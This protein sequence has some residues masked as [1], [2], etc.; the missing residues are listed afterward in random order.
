MTETDRRID[1]IDNR[2]Q[3]ARLA[4]ARA[5][6]HV[7]PHFT[8]RRVW[9]AAEWPV[10]DRAEGVYAWDVEGNRYLDGLSGLFCT[11]LGHGRRDLVEAMAAQAGRLAFSPT[12]N[13]T[14]PAAIAAAAAVAG[15]APDGLDH[16]F[17]VSSGS[18]AVESALKIVRCHHV[19][20]GRHERTKIIARRWSYHG[21]T[22][23]AL[24]VTGVPKLR[25][26]FE[27]V[28]FDGVT[29]A[30]NTR[31]AAVEGIDPAAAIEQAILDAGPDQV[32]AVF[33]EPVQNGGGAL[34]PPD[35][36][37]HALREIC[38]RHG[39]LLVADEV[40]CAFGRLGTPFGSHRVGA[41][42]DLITFAKGVTSAYVP[43]GGL[44]TTSDVLDPILDSQLGSFV[45]GSTFGAHPVAS[46]VA[47]AT[48][49][50]LHEEEV[51]EHVARTEAHL[52]DRLDALAVAHDSVAEV[53][54]CGFFY[55]IELTASRRRALP[56]T[57]EQSAQLLGG[58]LTRWI[59]DA[60]LLI[61]ADDR[62][63]TMLI[64]S[65]PL[66]S[67]REELDDL[68]E[69]IDAVLERVDAFTARPLT[70]PA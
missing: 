28:L 49:D 62:G 35:G 64:V 34:V 11:N 51:V 2:P 45:H 50:A 24:A 31:Q 53:R 9:G 15:F 14:H 54:G 66:V 42:P 16:V 12:W 4:R 21:T 5:R 68:V 60:G 46:A 38:D 70:I 56:L 6:R 40:I 13:M 26:P 43:M 55:A 25:A 33:A 10:I 19:A 1:A 7:I 30:P 67:T 47:V 52:R 65:P 41:A 37:W 69:R 22:L 44:V 57:D 58:L 63:A 23:G 39:V 29:H 61:R 3:D 17:F 27:A 20:N 32:A 18:E 48:I 36:Y 8:S 59:W